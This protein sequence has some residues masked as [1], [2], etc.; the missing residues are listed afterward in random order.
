MSGFLKQLE[1]EVSSEWETIKSGLFWNIMR[2]EGFNTELYKLLMLQIFHYTK[3]NAINQAVATYKINHTE[4]PLLRFCFKHA[5]EELGHEN[6][7]VRDLDSIGLYSPEDLAS[8]ALPATQALVGYL[9]HVAL[10]LG[11]LARLGYSYWAESSYGH[12]AEMTDHMKDDLNL[13]DNNMTFF[14]AHSAID[15]KHSAEV[16]D[17]IEKNVKTDTQ[18]KIVIDVARTTLYMTGVMFNNVAEVY[19]VNKKKKAVSA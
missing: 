5:L 4:V 12:L 17:A 9:Y 14:V 3:H 10:E 13:K 7:V 6:M 11:G 2:E 19:L 15:E 1:N 16:N 18:K 8:G